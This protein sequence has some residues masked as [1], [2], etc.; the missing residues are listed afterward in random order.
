MVSGYPTSISFPRVDDWS[1]NLRVLE[2]HIIIIVACLE[3]VGSGTG[4]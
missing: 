2:C 4:W 3:L 1:T